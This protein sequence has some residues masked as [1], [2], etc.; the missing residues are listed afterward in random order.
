LIRFLIWPLIWPVIEV[1]SAAPVSP[2]RP[3]R[4]CTTADRAIRAR[5][6]PERPHADAQAQPA[7][8]LARG[9]AGRRFVT[10][11][12]THGDFRAVSW[13]DVTA[14]DTA[15]WD[16]LLRLF[17]DE[18]IDPD[19]AVLY[20]T[21]EMPGSL[22]YTP[23][24][25]DVAG[26]GD[27]IYDHTEGRKLQGYVF[28]NDVPF[29]IDEPEQ[30]AMLF[31][32]EIGHRF[33]VLVQA[34]L[35]EGPTDE[36]LGRGLAHWSYFV[37]TNASPMEGNKWIDNDDGSF[38]TDTPPNAVVYH[39]LDLYLMGLLPP[40]QVEDTFVIRNPEP[41]GVDCFGFQLGRASVPQFCEPK[42]TL[43]GERKNFGVDD[44]IA[45]EGPRVPAWPD[46]Q[47]RFEVAFVLVA[48]PG[49]A[50]DV[51]LLR[52]LDDLLDRAVASY[53]EGTGGRADLVVVT[54]EQG[55]FQGQGG[56]C[57]I[58]GTTSPAWSAYVLLAV[59]RFAR[60][61]R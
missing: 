60:R 13:L 18:G 26:I 61:R 17:S 57:M 53:H 29:W 42:K 21:F 59:A 56:G 2:A 50:G 33:G 36:L 5:M 49:D 8:R 15:V 31:N 27:E 25:N 38:T 4:A 47:D 9:S 23:L 54:G 16:V 51:R 7:L 12:D 46:A 44:I 14:G 19:I 28:M 20:T 37:N 48:T 55:A 3:T 30:M 24:A 41:A 39:S 52:A 58:G 43:R 40:D 11:V 22:Y 10:Y 32:Q 35:G 34:D 1:V 45:V 6:S